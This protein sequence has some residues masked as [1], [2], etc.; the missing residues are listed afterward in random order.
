MGALPVLRLTSVVVHL[1]L[2]VVPHRREVRREHRYAVNYAVTPAHLN[3]VQNDL[4]MNIALHKETSQRQMNRLSQYPKAIRLEVTSSEYA[5]GL[6]NEK[7]LPQ[8]MANAGLEPIDV[9]GAQPFWYTT[10]VLQDGRISGWVRRSVAFEE[11]RGWRAEW[12]LDSEG[13]LAR[14][15][16][17][18]I[19][20][21][22]DTFKL[23]ERRCRASQR[24]SI[25][26]CLHAYQFDSG[27]WYDANPNLGI[28]MR[29]P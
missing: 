17:E 3:E 29:S 19:W 23:K 26:Q 14:G 1:S 6:F 10:A 2:H 13:G 25:N 11:G 22:G 12:I 21:H 7:S 20:D 24:K 27:F 5:N 18:G 9:E 8:R 4:Q 15:G 16:R 28:R